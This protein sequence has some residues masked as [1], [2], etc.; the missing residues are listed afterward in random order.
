[1]AKKSTARAT[2]MKPQKIHSY[3]I[4]IN[5]NGVHERVHLF[6]SDVESDME[7]LKVHLNDDLIGEFRD[8]TYYLRLNTTND[9]K[10]EGVKLP[11]TWGKVDGNNF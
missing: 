2:L 11:A 8:W 6:A 4:G 10:I 9:A 7:T 1:M 5:N 3:E